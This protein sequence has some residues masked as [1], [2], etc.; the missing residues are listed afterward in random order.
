G[1]DLVVNNPLPALTSISPTTK[2]AGDAAFV[3]TV[4]GSNFNAS[5]VVRFNG[6]DRVTTLVNSSQV[7]AQIA[8]ADVITAGQFPITV[9]NAAP[10]GGSS[11]ATNLIVNNPVPAI[12][13][14]SPNSMLEGSA[15]FTLT[16][17]GS[18]FVNGSVIQWN[19]AD[20]NTTFVNNSQLTAQISAADVVALGSVAIAVRNPQP[21]GGLSNSAAFTVEP[22]GRVITLVASNGSSNSSVIVPVT[23]FS[24]GNENAISF[25]LSFDTSLLSNPQAVVGKDAVGASL[26]TNTSQ[27]G[28]GH[29]GVSIT[30]PSGQAFS[31]GLREIV[32]ITFTTA[33]VTS[34][35]TTNVTFIDPP[36]VRRVLD[37]AGADLATI[38]GSG[39][40]NITIG[41]EA[42]VAPRPNGSNSGFIAISDWV[43]TGRFSAGLDVP[44]VGSEFQRADCAPKN[45]LGG[46]SITI[47]DWVQAGRYAS[48]LDPVVAAGGPTGPAAPLTPNAKS[49]TSTVESEALPS[50]TVRLLGGDMTTG[51][52]RQISIEIDTEGN[53]NALGFSLMFAPEKL[54]FVSA[55]KS[56]EL[57]SATLNVNELESKEGRVGIALA[58]PAGQTF[59]PGTH[60]VITLNFAAA[61]GVSEKM[62]FGFADQPI[63]REV[64]DINANSKKTLFQEPLGGTNP[65]EEAQFFV[66]QHYLDFLG[67]TADAGGLEYWTRQITE[68]GTDTACIAQRRIAVSASFFSSEE[69]QQTGYSVYRLYK[70]AY[71][72]RPSYQQFSADRSQLVGGPQLAASTAAFAEQFVQR[73]E[74]LRAYPDSLSAEEFVNRLFASA[75]V[76]RSFTVRRRATSGL[77]NNTLSRAQVLLELI[78]NKSFK[79]REYNSA[80]VLMQYFGYL[81]RAPDQGGYDFWLNV[82]NNREPGNYR[83]MICAFITSREYQERFSPIVPRS[84]QQCGQ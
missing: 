26:S 57:S 37:T 52:Q 63:A 42:D 38:Y 51:E 5:S 81:R 39:I 32:K 4:N 70:A 15:A 69:F 60:Q 50:T 65:L 36:V 33:P 59:G 10:G 24:Q 35:T 74:F 71:G 61:A 12:N 23:L 2:I 55:E 21:G 11:N 47:S 29:Y 79:E 43:Q 73:P 3:L 18:H 25:S 8:A 7:T 80:F 78:E 48:G 34:L 67:R 84:N 49:S 30:L 19:G 45:T 54:R 13:T 76:E 27:L 20:R 46:G 40:V 44:A 64:V 56:E 1:I 75:G 16:V 72:Q 62:L 83:G 41:F 77:S 14:I 28:Q 22:N 31:A 6:S 58:L 82:L 53:E 17:D 9:F 66:A 68:C